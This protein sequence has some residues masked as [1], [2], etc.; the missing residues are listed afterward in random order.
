MAPL[1]AQQ[2]RHAEDRRAGGE[3]GGF[4]E[5]ATVHAAGLGR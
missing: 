2:R 5:V 3:R 1:A 4:D